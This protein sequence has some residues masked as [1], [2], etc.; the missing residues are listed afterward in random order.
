MQTFNQ[1]NGTLTLDDVPIDS[2]FARRAAPV[3]RGGPGASRRASVRSLIRRSHGVH[4][5]CPALRDG[6]VQARAAAPVTPFV[7]RRAADAPR[8]ASCAAP[9]RR[10]LRWAPWR[11]LWTSVSARRRAWRREAAGSSPGSR[12]RG[13]LTRRAASQIFRLDLVSPKRDMALA[14]GSVATAE[15][16][17]RLAWSPSGVETGE[18]PVRRARAA[19]PAR[20]TR[21]AEVRLRRVGRC[22]RSWA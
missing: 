4:Q 11:A 5:V 7:L 1:W 10:C 13:R 22:A 17:H 21:R 15:R 2:A 16:F 14:G 19:A 8:A 3:R 20:A 6:G 18:L 12:A 9:P